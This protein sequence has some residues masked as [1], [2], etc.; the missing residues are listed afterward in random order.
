MT[1]IPYHY[2]LWIFITVQCVYNIFLVCPAFLSLD[3]NEPSMTRFLPLK[4]YVF[5]AS[6]AT[7]LVQN[8]GGPVLVRI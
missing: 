7:S 2:H 1:L 8:K 3:D 6:P 5:S 4:V